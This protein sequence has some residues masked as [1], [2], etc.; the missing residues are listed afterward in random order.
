MVWEILRDG[1]ASSGRSSKETGGRNMVRELGLGRVS[2]T[3][4]VACDGSSGV[5]GMMQVM[6]RS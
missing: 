1:L 3:D 2:R 4:F 5:Q 6:W